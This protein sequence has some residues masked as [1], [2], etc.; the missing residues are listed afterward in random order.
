MER[1]PEP[2][3][4]DIMVGSP[5]TAAPDTRIVEVVRLMN[6]HR[7][8]AVVVAEEGRPVGIFTERD[9]LN[10][11]TWMD[12]D[13]IG[14]PVQEYMTPQ[15][16][17]AEAD[18]PW[19]DAMVRMDEGAIRHL[20]VVDGGRLVGMLSVR[21]LI[22]HQTAFLEAAVLRRTE[23]LRSKNEL[24]EERDRERSHHLALAGEIQRRL[25]PERAPRFEPVRIAAHLASYDG[26]AGDFYDLRRYDDAQLGLVVADVSGHGVPAAFVTVMAKHCYAENCRHVRSPAEVLRRLNE[27]L[28][29]PLG[30]DQFVTMCAACV[31]RAAGR[32]FVATA[33]H[34]APL[35]YRAATRTVEV[36]EVGG[37]MLGVVAGETYEELALDLAPG[38]RALFYTD[39]VPETRDPAGALFGE[40]ALAGTLVAGA[41]DDLDDLVTRIFGVLAAH[42]DGGP[43]QDDATLVLLELGA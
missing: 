6:A 36:P 42:R 3:V 5:V 39:G 20:P 18:E 1:S 34:P 27:F 38:D 14:D 12:E 26:V 43:S 2:R 17:T 31:D 21:D 41:A 9:V 30:D 33:G 32:L 7:I 40:E 23:E 16:V 25:L 8:G 13:W 11:I 37:M 22:H 10:C 24:L 19:R 15:L 35:V 29:G 4:R 28:I